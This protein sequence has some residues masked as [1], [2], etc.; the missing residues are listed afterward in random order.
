M[1][2]VPE[3]TLKAVLERNLPEDPRY[4][5]LVSAT[6]K[7][8][9]KAGWMEESDLAEAESSGVDRAQIFELIA[10]IGLKT[11]TNYINHIQQTEVDEALKP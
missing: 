9:E 10:I 8:Q 7:L 3:A 1:N 6:W 5:A 11:I 2:E 4:R